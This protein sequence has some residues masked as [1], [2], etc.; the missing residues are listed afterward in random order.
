M[1]NKRQITGVSMVEV[2]VAL[3]VMSVGMLGIASL[4]VTALQAKT[5]SQS[6]MQAVNLANDMADRIRANSNVSAS[7]IYALTEGTV[8]SSEPSTVCVSNG[9]TTPGTICTADQ[10]AAYDKY[11]WSAAAISTL[12]GTVKRSIIATDPTPTTPAIYTITLKWTEPTGGGELS[13][14]MQVQ[15]CTSPCL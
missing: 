14:A 7:S 1:L 11:L 2:L 13:Y 4:Y 15:T 6:R 10:L 12:P 8:L 5:T 9:T 3:V